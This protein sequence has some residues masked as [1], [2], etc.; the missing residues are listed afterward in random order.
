MT[1]LHV[2]S[3]CLAG[4]RGKRNQSPSVGGERGVQNEGGHKEEKMSTKKDC[5]GRGGNVAGERGRRK[6]EISKGAQFAMENL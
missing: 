2:A 5:G 6:G 3:G 4:G 1:L